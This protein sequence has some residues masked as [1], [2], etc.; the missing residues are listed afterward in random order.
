MLLAALSFIWKQ[1]SVDQNT[2]VA[3]EDEDTSPDAESYWRLLPLLALVLAAVFVVKLTNL[4]FV[5][6]PPLVVIGFEIFLHTK[7]CP[8]ATRTLS[9]PVV[10]MLTAAGGLFCRRYLGVGVASSVSS[11]AWGILILRVFDLHVPPALAVA[12]LPQVIDAPTALYPV[13]VVIGT[14]LLSGSFVLYNRVLRPYFE[15]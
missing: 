6:F 15:S 14:S 2:I 3:S 5:L 10:C 8:W 13:A 4:R 9:L 1:M 11:M 7:H 12:L